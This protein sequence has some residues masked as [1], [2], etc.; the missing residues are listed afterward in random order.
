KPEHP[1]R[2]AARGKSPVSR[3]V[4]PIEL[5]DVPDSD[6]PGWRLKRVGPSNRALRYTD[7]D[8][9][10]EERNDLLRRIR[11]CALAGMTEYEIEKELG[12]RHMSLRRWAFDDPAVHATLAIPESIAVS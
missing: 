6:A 9:Y 11:D 10:G 4:G 3:G 12:I 5:A 8:L 7:A 1:S 2:I